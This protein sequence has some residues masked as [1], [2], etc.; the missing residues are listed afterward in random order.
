MKFR[1]L[2]KAALIMEGEVNPDGSRVNKWRLSSIQTI[3]EIKCLL[4]IIPIWASGIICLTAIVQQST[5][6]GSQALK[7][8]RHLGPH[9]Q[10]PAGSMV[11]ISFITIGIVI[12]I[13][14]TVLV[15]FMRKRTKIEGG[16]TLLQRMGIGFIFSV[17]SMFVAGLIEPKRRASALAHG[18]GIAPMSVLWLA[19][20]L[21]LMGLCEAFNIVGQIEFFNREFP[22]NMLSVANSLFSV[23]MAGSN[24]VSLII[25]NVVHNTTGKNGHPDWLTKDLNRGKLENFYFVLA[26]LGILNFGYF[27]FVAPRY[28]YKSK[29]LAEEEEKGEETASYKGSVEISG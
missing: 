19:P 13:Y 11:V 24:Y 23:T 16:I 25:V 6:T 9:F 26:G 2:N 21:I 18:G 17:L 4:R 12:P 28:R 1:F 14:D 15:P 22:E 10:I 29:L 27:L 8:D 7:M 3:Q 5:F 20:Q